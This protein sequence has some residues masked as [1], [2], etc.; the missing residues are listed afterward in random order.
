MSKDRYSGD[1]TI[2]TI[3]QQVGEPGGF[4]YGGHINLLT[5][6]RGGEITLRTAGGGGDAYGFRGGVIIGVGSGGAQGEVSIEL[7][8]QYDDNGGSPTAWHHMFL[9]SEHNIYIGRDSE[10]NKGG[11]IY[12]YSGDDSYLK[13]GGGL[14]TVHNDET[15]SANQILFEVES[16]HADPAFTVDA[17]GD[18]FCAGS[19]DGDSLTVTGAISGG[20]LTID[21]SSGNSLIDWTD[22]QAESFKFTSTDGGI[23][24]VAAYEWPINIEVSG[25]GTDIDLYS[26][27]GQIEV[28]GEFGVYIDS[29][30]GIY[31]GTANAQQSGGAPTQGVH[32]EGASITLES[33]TGGCYIK[34]AA[35][36]DYVLRVYNESGSNNADGI[37]IDLNSEG[38]GGSGAI[39]ANNW[40]QFVWDGSAMGA[41]QGTEDAGSGYGWAVEGNVA[42][43]GYY[44]SNSYTDIGH[45]QFV[46][47]TA[48]FGEFFEAGDPSEWKDMSD[49]PSG[50]ILKIPEGIIVWVIGAKFYRKKQ[51]NIGVPMF[52]TKRSIIVGSGTA[53]LKGHPDS[54]IGEVL[55]FIGQLPVFIKGKSNVG[56]LVIPI[57][58]ESYCKCI[59]KKDATFQDY[60]AALGT[61]LELCEEEYVLPS[62][63]PQ[64]PGKK[65]DMKLI[66]C[67]VGVK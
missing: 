8:N 64:S 34:R 2:E 32:L 16:D 4:D 67:A 51:N 52:V 33:S 12:S 11:S 31:I 50:S 24:L 56:D 42:A 35:S 57:D 25:T 14:V 46:S 37:Q 29:V 44:A 55:S 48:D 40:I 58:N 65:V 22:V 1:H 26:P 6:E 60:M 3:G 20:S 10:D 21:G 43:Q 17:E 30:L 38:D 45:A 61:S 13:V 59:S 15:T 62:D 27:G 49:G 36:S 5:A 9:Y 23:D 63:H 53:L 18:V 54:R 7:K 28:V 39:A 41:I 47:G 19:I 66:L